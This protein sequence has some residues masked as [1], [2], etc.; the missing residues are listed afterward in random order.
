MKNWN[1]PLLEM[2]Y[3]GDTFEVVEAA[4]KADGITEIHHW[5]MDNP[6]ERDGILTLVYLPYRAAVRTRKGS[7]I[8]IYHG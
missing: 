2:Q 8:K 7:V 5:N 4:L 3:L 6:K 1:D